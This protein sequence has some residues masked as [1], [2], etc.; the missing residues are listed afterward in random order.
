MKN[1][2]YS[3]EFEYSVSTLI[4]TVAVTL[5]LSI[6]MGSFL[7]NII[8]LG[9]YNF[10]FSI[11]FIILSTYIILPSIKDSI[12][13]W[14]ITDKYIEYV[15]YKTN[16]EKIKGFHNIFSK[17]TDSNCSKIKLSEIKSIRIF[18]RSF[19]SFIL[20]SSMQHPIYFGITLNDGSYISFK[21][22]ITSDHKYFVEAVKYLQDKCNITIY[23]NN[24][25]LE[26]LED[27]SQNIVAYIEN[28]E[29]NKIKGIN[30]ED[31]DSKKAEQ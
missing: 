10:L 1:K 19:T 8:S 22:L 31:S 6:S 21:S 30:I 23:D 29:K 20:N 2:I 13:S 3:L 5:L 18:Y 7:S 15:H 24:N 14:Y 26:V 4:L 17:N 11:G 9:Q 28:I 25:L 16:L 12:D 27:S